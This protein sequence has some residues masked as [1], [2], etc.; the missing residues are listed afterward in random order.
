M[1]VYPLKFKPILKECLWGGT[2]LNAILHK[3]L[4]STRTGESWELSGVQGAISEVANG[5]LAGMSLRTLITQAGPKLLGQ[6]VLERFGEHF[7]ILI[8]FIDA[9]QDLSIQVHPNDALAQK[10]HNSAGKTELWYIMDV[11]PGAKLITGFSKRIDQKE[12]IKNL[13]EGTLLD[14]LHHEA[15]TAGDAFFI[16]P[17]TIHAIGAG[18][19]LAEIQQTSDITYRVFDFNRKDTHGNLRPLHTTLALDALDYTAKKEAKVPYSCTQNTANE[20]VDCPYFT[21]YFLDLTQDMEWD[22][23]A[24]D[25]FTIYVCVEGQAVITNDW[26]STSVEKGETVLIAAASRRVAI[27]TQGATF[28]EVTI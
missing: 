9:A 16:P 25:A 8:K 11:D 17:G 21:T 2:K 1:N 23:T 4:L 12:Y 10:R 28:L 20:V 18:V 22:L 5:A 13:E 14:V 3:P 6:R 19:L 26:G 7:P 27:A 15:I 24:R